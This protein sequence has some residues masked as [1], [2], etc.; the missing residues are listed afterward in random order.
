MTDG[1]ERWKPAGLVLLII[2]LTLVL[3]AAAAASPGDTLFTRS[4]DVTVHEAPADEAPVVARL[5]RGEKLKEFRRQGAWVKVLLYSRI[6]LDGW[7]RSSD[8]GPPDPEASEV[9][10]PVSA[11]EPEPL[12][13][14]ADGDRFIIR[15]GGLP[16]L[17]FRADCEI[18]TGSGERVRRKLSGASPKAYAVA[19]EA[20]SCK[21]EKDGKPGRLFV[22]LE[23]DERVV[24]CHSTTGSFN[25]VRVRSVGPWGE[26]QG[27]TCG[28]GNRC[29]ARRLP[30]A[31]G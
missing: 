6:G 23:K 8:V 20:V 19:A 1:I 10:A 15:V 22:T 16:F 13:A 7:V 11:V 26:A 24:A 25:W 30:C 27:W 2:G 4:G 12:D 29:V 18:V 28:T 14:P 9:E 17:G 5:A 3:A 31:A 21:V